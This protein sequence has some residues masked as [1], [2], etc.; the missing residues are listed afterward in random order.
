M[1]KAETAHMIRT[2][3]PP[4]GGRGPLALFGL[5]PLAVFLFLFAMIV[6]DRGK[7]GFLQYHARV[8]EPFLSSVSTAFPTTDADSLFNRQD[9]SLEE[10][11]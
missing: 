11:I 9:I 6:G 2:V 8:Q 1:N 4:P 3:L 5:A 10:V 7:C